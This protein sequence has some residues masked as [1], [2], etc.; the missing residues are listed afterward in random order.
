MAAGKGH[1]QHCERQRGSSKS[2]PCAGCGG[3]TEGARAAL[4]S[5]G[6][7]V[8][9]GHLWKRTARPEAMEVV[10]GL[11]D[12]CAPRQPYGCF[13]FPSP[14]RGTPAITRHSTAEHG[15]SRAPGPAQRNPYI[16]SAADVRWRGEQLYFYS[17]ISALINIPSHGSRGPGQNSWEPW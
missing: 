11:W 14:E 8:S 1:G 2:Q 7:A 5:M 16:S 9:H 17:L 10:R 3:D 15:D 12:L 4:S 6:R 13:Q